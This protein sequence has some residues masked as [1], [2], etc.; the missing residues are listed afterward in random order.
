MA[1]LLL[2]PVVPMVIGALLVRVLPQR[3]GNVVVIAAPLAALAAVAALDLGTSVTV[4]FLS[5]ELEVLRADA[6]A[7]PFGVIFAGVALIAAIYG[8]PPN[9]DTNAPPPWSTRAPPWGWST[10]ATS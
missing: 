6:L 9:G 8:L 4:D 10:P 3:A 1:D 5:W 2:H 7:R